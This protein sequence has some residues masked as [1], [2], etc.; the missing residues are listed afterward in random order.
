MKNPGPRIKLDPRLA[1]YLP[2]VLVIIAAVAVP[3]FLATYWVFLCTAAFLTAI[4]AMGLSII[5]GWIGEISLATAGLLGTSV[6]ITGYLL[7]EGESNWN[8]WPF[9]AALVLGVL[10]PM[11]LAALIAIPTARF[12]G[13]YV[14]VLTMG[15]QITLERTLFANPGIIGGFGRNII[16]PRPNIFGLSFDSDLR[17]FYLCFAA[18]LIAALFVF[19][20]RRSRH[21]YAMNLVRIDSRTAAAVGI[22]PLRY[23]IIAFAVGGALIGFAGAFTAPLYRT[24]PAIIQYILFQSL[25]MLAIPIVSGTQSQSGIFVVA[26]MFGLIPQALE[27]HRW[28]PYLLGGVGLVVGT[29]AGPSG[30]G[31]NVLDVVQKIKETRILAALSQKRPGQEATVGND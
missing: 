3:W 25:F 18:F 27:S 10:A 16:V 31:G 17:Y 22:S 4:T 26:M 12:S 23:K 1:P 24:P 13:V 28:S 5:V 8:H 30:M 2:A 6:Y 21:G 7:R 29:L 9:M 15:L 11:A 20:L 14:M 19:L